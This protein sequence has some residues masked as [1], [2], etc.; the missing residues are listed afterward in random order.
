MYIISLTRQYTSVAFG[1]MQAIA[2]ILFNMKA[3]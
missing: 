3:M 1:K 2:F